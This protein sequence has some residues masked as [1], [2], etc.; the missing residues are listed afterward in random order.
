MPEDELSDA[1]QSPDL[2][3]RLEAV[4]RAALDPARY[5]KSV[6]AL[7]PQFPGEAYF[8]FER[9]GY[10]GVEIVPHLVALAESNRDEHVR[11]F[12]ALGL[13]RFKRVLDR[14]TLL[15]AIRHRS[16]YQ[17]LACQALVWLGSVEFLP[18]LLDEL[19]VTSPV[20]DWNR[21]VSLVNAIESLGGKIPMSER[22]RLIAT[23]PL[24]TKAM[25]DCKRVG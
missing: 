11:L 17:G 20:A 2:Q 15:N 19:R 6:V 12:A 16:E 5:A 4:E 23:G 13:A 21:L 14:T 8:I 10:F 7:I 1:L 9:V 25:L 24:L 18:S 3:T 22:E